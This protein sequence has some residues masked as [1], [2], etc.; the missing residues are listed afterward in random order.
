[1]SDNGEEMPI[2]PDESSEETDE[3]VPLFAPGARED[4]EEEVLQ[5]WATA[6][7]E[8]QITRLT[9]RPDWQAKATIF[10]LAALGVAAV[11]FMVHVLGGGASDDRSAG[12]EAANRTAAIEKMERREAR[13]KAAVRERANAHQRQRRIARRKAIRERRQARREAERESKTDT[14]APAEATLSGTSATEPSASPPP[15][16]EPAPAP[17]PTPPPAPAASPVRAAPTQATPGQA[18]DAFGPGP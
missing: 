2:D 5:E 6:P 7:E 1:M 8:E 10:G 12:V 9:R 11:V 14:S 16:S 13:Q 4:D 3:L 18:A 15:A 17:V